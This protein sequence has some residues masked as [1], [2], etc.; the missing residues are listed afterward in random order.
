MNDIAR[1]CADSVRMTIRIPA[2]VKKVTAGL[3]GRA[4]LAPGY[5]NL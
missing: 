1:L 4:R 2:P 3:L 5:E